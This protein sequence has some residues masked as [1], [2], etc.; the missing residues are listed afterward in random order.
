MIYT[1]SYNGEAYFADQVFALTDEQKSLASDY[2]QNL[3]LFV[4]AGMIQTVVDW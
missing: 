1:I 2:A 4:G 3:S